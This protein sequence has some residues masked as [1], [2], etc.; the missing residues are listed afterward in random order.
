MAHGAKAA[1]AGLPPQAPIPIELLAQLF[2]REAAEQMISVL[3]GGTLAECV[4]WLQDRLLAVKRKAAEYPATVLLKNGP[5][6][7]FEKPRVILGTIHSVKGGEADVCYL[8]PDLVA[9]AWSSGRRLVS[10]AIA[11]SGSSTSE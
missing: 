9:L 3:N 11:S 5:R 6:A 1:V 10:A 8:F 7:L 2:E 4:R